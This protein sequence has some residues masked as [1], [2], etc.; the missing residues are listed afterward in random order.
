MRIMR[1]VFSRQG[2]IGEWTRKLFKEKKVG[3]MKIEGEWSQARSTSPIIMKF[4][5]D[6]NIVEAAL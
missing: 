4:V 2:N 6:T 1:R 3:E 5:I